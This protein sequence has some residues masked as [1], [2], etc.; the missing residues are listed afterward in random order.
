MKRRF[1]CLR[2]SLVS[3]EAP[4]II[5]KFKTAP[6][7]LFFFSPLPFSS[8]LC[9]L[10][11]AAS[12]RL[13]LRLTLLMEQVS[14][15]CRGPGEFGATVG[16]RRLGSLARLLTLVAQE[17][18]KRRELAAVAAVLPALRLGPALNDSDGRGPVVVRRPAGLHHRWHG[19]HHGRL[20]CAAEV[21]QLCCG[22]RASL[23]FT[24]A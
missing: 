7:L 10:S 12:R 19:V 21:S 15:P 8:L 3:L 4:L 6:F 16:A 9:V 13:P 23:V 1:N 14:V 18:A 2:S 11:V 22:L 5:A 17:V 20:V 24:H